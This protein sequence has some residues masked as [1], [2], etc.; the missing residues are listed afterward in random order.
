MQKN[1]LATQTLTYTF[2]FWN[3]NAIRN[4]Y[5]H[6]YANAFNLNYSGTVHILSLENC[7]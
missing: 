3:H 7:L 6:N 4:I 2:A 5:I 1:A